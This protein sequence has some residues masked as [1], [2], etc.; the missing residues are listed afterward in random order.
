MRA[1]VQNVMLCYE[2]NIKEEADVAQTELCGISSDPRPV[3]LKTCV[4]QKLCHRQDTTSEIEEY[5]PDRPSLSAF[6]LV[7]EVGL[8]NIFQKCC[9][10]LDVSE[11][12]DLEVCQIGRLPLCVLT[13]STQVQFSKSASGSLLFDAASATATK[14]AV[15]LPRMTVLVTTF[16]LWLTGISKDQR[17]L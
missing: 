3:S 10:E 1:T 12:V 2:Y 15:I 4:Y 5:L 9:D 13:V 14:T 7:I 6:A 8:G 11:D 17:R 16:M